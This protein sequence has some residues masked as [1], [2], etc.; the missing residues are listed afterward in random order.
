MAT[1]VTRSASRGRWETFSARPCPERSSSQRSHSCFVFSPAPRSDFSRC[2]G[3]GTLWTASSA[4]QR[5]CSLRFIPVILAIFGLIFAAASGWLPIGG[6]SSL[7]ASAFSAWGRG[8]DYL[9]HLVLPA[10][11]LIL[12]MLPGFFL[13]A[14]GVMADLLPSP[15]VAAGRAFGLSE[16][17]LVLRHLLPV[18]MASL[19]SYASSS[20]SRLLNASFL[21]EVVTGWPGMGRLAFGALRDGTCFFSWERFRSPRR[22]FFS[23]TSS[24]ICS[25][26][27][28][29]RAFGSKRLRRESGGDGF[30]F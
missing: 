1:S 25:S 12:V 7:S 19:V 24:S 20:V 13:H 30:S 23:A 3:W 6:G 29:T 10:T 4:A 16:R 17:R 2:D 5:W 21:V 18:S 28:R 14:R 8:A 26:R 15:F 27:R 9:W 11:V 22:F